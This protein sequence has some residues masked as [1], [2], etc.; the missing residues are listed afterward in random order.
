V[1]EL[2]KVLA[3]RE[4]V[5]LVRAGQ[6]RF[7]CCDDRR[8]ELAVRRLRESEA[9]YPARHRI[10]IGSIGRHRVVRIGDGDDP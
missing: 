7:E 6:D 5:F 3:T 9:G 10:P 2:E 8:V 4:S 1:T